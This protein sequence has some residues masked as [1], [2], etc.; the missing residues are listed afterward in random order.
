MTQ[1]LSNNVSYSYQIEENFANEQHLTIAKAFKPVLQT[2]LTDHQYYNYFRKHLT[3]N[4][5]HQLLHMPM[6]KIITSGR[7]IMK[8][9]IILLNCI[10]E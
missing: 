1:Q 10:Q 3:N 5:V 7:P 6:P 9:F 2:Y 4:H 8:T